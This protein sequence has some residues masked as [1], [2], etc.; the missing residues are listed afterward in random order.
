[1]Y[2]IGS[3]DEVSNLELCG[4]LLDRMSI[5]HDTPEQLR[6]WIKHTRDRPFNDRRYAV[7]DTKLRRL[8]W[9]QKVSIHEGLK[10]TVDWFTQFGE[11]WWG[12]ISHALAPFPVV[13][14]GKMMTN[15]ACWTRDEPPKAQDTKLQDVQ[16][17]VQ[18]KEDLN[19]CRDRVQN[20]DET[21]SFHRG[22]HNGGG[23]FHMAA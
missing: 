9:E 11:S 1:V 20:G 2:N 12:D 14:D 19:G 18:K 22:V 21:T 3:C 15:D 17:D 10:I 23:E 7:D 8:G 6:K 4:L 5:P 16:Q 13:R